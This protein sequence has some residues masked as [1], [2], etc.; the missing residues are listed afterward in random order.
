MNKS[1]RTLS[2]NRK[3]ATVFIIEIT[4]LVGV[5]I[6]PSSFNQPSKASF[7][8]TRKKKFNN[9]NNPSIGFTC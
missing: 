7:K 4:E 6:T 2:H 3:K 9:L 1:L 5:D 8:I